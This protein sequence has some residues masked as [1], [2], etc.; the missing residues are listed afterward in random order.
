MLTAPRLH[1]HSTSM[2]TKRFTLGLL[3]TSSCLVAFGVTSDKLEFRASEGTSLTKSFQI[4][5]TGSIGN[6]T[7]EV[8]GNDIGAFLG[9]MEVESGNESK[10]VFTDTYDKVDDGRVIK[11]TRSFSTLS[12]STTVSFGSQLGSESQNIDVASVLEGESASFQWDPEEQEYKA[13]FGDDSGLEDELLAHL[14]FESDLR[15]LLPDGEVKADDTWEVPLVEFK[16]ILSPGGKLGWMSEDV[17][18]MDMD[19]FADIAEKIQE[20]AEALMI[21]ALI[22]SATCT[23]KGLREIDGVEFGLIEIE[24]KF[25][26]ALDMI[27]FFT[28]LSTAILEALPDGIELKFDFDTLELDISLKATGNA[29]WDL[30]A[31]H[32]TT[33][34]LTSDADFAFDVDMHV[35][36]PSEAHSVV[37]YMEMSMQMENEVQFSE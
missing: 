31:G 18:N 30:S 20:K 3:L 33:L 36:I 23:Y 13:S 17:P 25:E 29:Y 19:A 7:L 22:G 9:D 35:E 21:E 8:D 14:E 4:S 6:L 1:T 5:T 34:S 12:N 11:L 28:Q 2:H 32:L 24:L 15:F 26:V 37:A 10:I 27:P 16:Q